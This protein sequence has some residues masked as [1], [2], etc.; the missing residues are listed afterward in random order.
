MFEI[1]SRPAKCLTGQIVWIR[2]HKQQTLFDFGRTEP[3]ALL[4]VGKQ[5]V[6]FEQNSVVWVNLRWSNKERAE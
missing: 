1:C 4:G 5:N 3:P 2:C 6:E